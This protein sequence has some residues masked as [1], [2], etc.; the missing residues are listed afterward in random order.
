[1]FLVFNI[2]ILRYSR[3]PRAFLHRLPFY[4]V[5]SR[6]EAT[7][8]STSS[9]AFHFSLLLLGTDYI[10]LCFSSR[11]S[12]LS[13]FLFQEFFEYSLNLKHVK[14]KSE[15]KF[16]IDTEDNW[17][18]LNVSFLQLDNDSTTITCQ[19]KNKRAKRL[20]RKKKR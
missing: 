12:I 16:L 2:S 18:T 5:A 3:Y 4:D 10:A 7:F 6:I 13:L 17:W 8:E 1:M 9:I 14:K 15:I 20:E 19:L 11:R